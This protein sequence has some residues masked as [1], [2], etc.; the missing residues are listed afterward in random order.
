MAHRS[1][2]SSTGTTS[3]S[4]R[5]SSSASSRPASRSSPDPSSTRPSPRHRRDAR[6]H[7]LARLPGVDPQRRS[8]RY[9][10]ATFGT[11]PL[12]TVEAQIAHAERTYHPDGIFLDNVPADPTQLAYFRELS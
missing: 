10:A 8:G 6:A 3:A 1:P 9:D 5:R 4:S 12:A 11:R 2:S 7:G